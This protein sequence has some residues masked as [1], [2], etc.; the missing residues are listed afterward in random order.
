MNAD[1]AKVMVG[2]YTCGDT[3]T[4]QRRPTHD[5]MLVL[6]LPMLDMLFLVDQ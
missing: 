2:G 5:D 1:L 6:T 3:T 4:L